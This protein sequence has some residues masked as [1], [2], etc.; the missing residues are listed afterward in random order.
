MVWDYVCVSVIIFLCT[1][2]QRDICSLIVK[3]D[4]ESAVHTDAR[5][6]LKSV[7]YDQLIA[8]LIEAVKE[9]QVEIDALKHEIETLKS[10][11]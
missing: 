5:T 11:K 4:A 3:S 10:D 7:E 6:G 9:Q 2:T 8:P 1:A